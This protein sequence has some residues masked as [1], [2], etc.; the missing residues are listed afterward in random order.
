MSN[1][2]KSRAWILPRHACSTTDFCKKINCSTKSSVHDPTLKTRHFVDVITEITRSMEIH[3][4]KGTILGGVHLELTGEVNDDGYSVVCPPPPSMG[5]Q[6]LNKS[7]EID[8]VHWWFDGVG[9]QGL[10]IQL[11]NPL[12][13]AFELRAVSRSV[14]AVEMSKSLLADSFFF[15]FTDVAFLLADYLKSKRRGER[16]HDILLSSLRGRRNDSQK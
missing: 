15:F 1:N 8:R 4:E 10:V 13:P 3:R 6:K 5:E 9:G 2:I 11:Q 14:A 12:R 16:P 7:C